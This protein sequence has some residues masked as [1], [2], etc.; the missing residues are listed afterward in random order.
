[1]QSN[2]DNDSDSEYTSD[3]ENNE[4]IDHNNDLR[5]TLT[6][7]FNDDYQFINNCSRLNKVSQLYQSIL[8]KYFEP[9]AKYECYLEYSR[10]SNINSRRVSRLHVHGILE[11]KNYICMGEFYLNNLHKINDYGIL[12]I[13]T[14]KDYPVWYAYCTKDI[15]FM[16]DLCNLYHCNSTYNN[17]DK[18]PLNY[19]LYFKSI[20][21][22]QKESTI[23]QK[24]LNSGCD[25]KE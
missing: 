6:I 13:D 16:E 17:N 3:E 8:L 22:K 9:Y 25:T 18:R 4:I 1:M 21:E 5:R 19:N 23:M 14:I 15:P 10:P 2:S 12:E 24:L 20:I 7:N 11:F